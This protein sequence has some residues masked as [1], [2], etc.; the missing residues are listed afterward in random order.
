MATPAM[1]D[2]FETTAGTER[3]VGFS[4]NVFSIAI[5]LLVLDIQ[6]PALPPHPGSVLL[7]QALVAVLP[8]IGTYA[9]SFL[10]V[11]QFWYLHHLRFRY[12]H[13]CDRRL[14]WLNLLLLLVIGFVPFT[15]SVLSTYGNATGYALYDGT[16]AVV[17]LLSAAM[18]AYATYG[19]RLV[20]PGL[21][22]RV[23][24][25]GLIRSLSSA[26]VFTLAAVVAQIDVAFSR[27]LWLLLVPSAIGHMGL[28]DLLRRAPSARDG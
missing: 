4:D 16:M 9:L 14:I 11:G 25:L 20:Q 26:C 13:R 10:V 19:N 8:K 3:L 17:A 12:I 5:T 27:W 18:W 15:T 23:R 22:P 21:D 6:L 7:A 2:A 28:R 1:D 24:W